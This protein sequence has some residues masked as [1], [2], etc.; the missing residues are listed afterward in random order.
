[1][2]LVIAETSCDGGAQ[3]LTLKQERF[4]II[5]SQ[6]NATLPP[7]KWQVPVT[8]GRIGA[9]EQQ[10]LLLDGNAEIAAGKCGEAVKVNFGDIGYYRVDYGPKLRGALTKATRAD[11]AGGPRQFPRR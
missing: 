7:L 11:D 9:A 5:P 4:T 6:A 10:K 2:P 1:M 3:R 8:I